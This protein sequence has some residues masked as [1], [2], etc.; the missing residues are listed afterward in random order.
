MPENIV[1]L[2]VSWADFGIVVKIV[3]QLGW[4]VQA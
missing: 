3:P 1:I 2:V 4:P